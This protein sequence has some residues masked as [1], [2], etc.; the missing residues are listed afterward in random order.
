MKALLLVLFPVIALAKNGIVSES[1][2]WS[3]WSG[4]SSRNKEEIKTY[5]QCGHYTIYDTMESL[6][7]NNMEHSIARIDSGEGVMYFTTVDGKVLRISVKDAS[8]KAEND[9]IQCEM[10]LD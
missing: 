5:Y 2:A 9:Y 10:I 8:F 3:N 6:V 7:I 4:N 1:D